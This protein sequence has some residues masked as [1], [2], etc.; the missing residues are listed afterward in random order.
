M[1]ESAKLNVLSNERNGILLEVV[2]TPTE[3]KFGV[4][5]TIDHLGTTE[6]VDAYNA[7]IISVF[8]KAGLTP[9]HNTALT[10]DHQPGKQ[11]WEIPIEQVGERSE[12]EIAHTAHLLLEAVHNEATQ[13]L[14]STSET[15][16]SE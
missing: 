4:F 7:A 9:R 2:T 14:A 3:E 13:S 10:E 16:Q 1:I 12:D 15:T 6:V 5:L 11:Y 8:G